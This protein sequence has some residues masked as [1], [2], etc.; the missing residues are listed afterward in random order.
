L[1]HD[2]PFNN[3]N[4]RTALVSMLVFLDENGLVITCDEDSLFKMLL[5]LAQ[6]A[7][8]QGPREELSDRETLHVAS[9][10]A[11][12]ARWLEKGDRA[13]PWRRLRQILTSHGCEFEFPRGVGN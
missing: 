10:I 3:G 4:K 5:Q 7:L 12:C 8:V 9:W 11:S 2:H 6:H 13:L 1:V